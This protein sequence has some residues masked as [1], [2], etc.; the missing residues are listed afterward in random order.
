MSGKKKRVTLTPKGN[1]RDGSE[2]AKVYPGT[3]KKRGV[4]YPCYFVRGWKENG[5]WQRK[6][7]SDKAKAEAE[8]ATININLKNTGQQRA[9]V[10]STL[11]EKQ[12][13]QAEQAFKDLGSYSLSDAVPYQLTAMIAIRMVRTLAGKICQTSFLGLIIDLRL[14]LLRGFITVADTSDSLNHLTVFV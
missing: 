7:F 11:S 13:Q 14:I 4:E 3:Y 9:L 10:L 12:T 2:E 6:Q 5:K 8:A 1:V